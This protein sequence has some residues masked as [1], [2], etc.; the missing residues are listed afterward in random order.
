MGHKDE[1]YID[2]PHYDFDCTVLLEF[3]PARTVKKVVS[4]GNQD[5]ATMSYNYAC[6]C[7]NALRVFSSFLLTQHSPVSENLR[8]GCHPVGTFLECSVLL[9]QFSSY[10]KNNV[11]KHSQ[12]YKHGIGLNFWLKRLAT[13]G[14]LP[15]NLQMPRIKRR[16]GDLKRSDAPS[17]ATLL[18]FPLPVSVEKEFDL[19]ADQFGWGEA[20]TREAELIYKH[21]A[22]QLK[23][24]GSDVEITHDKIP[25]LVAEILFDRLEVLRNFAED[26]F[27]QARKERLRGLLMIRQGRKH[28]PFF[29]PFMAWTKGKGKEKTNPFRKRVLELSPEQ[30]DQA[31]LAWCYFKND[32]IF[33]RWGYGSSRAY[34]KWQKMKSAVGSTLGAQ[35]AQELI[36]C[37]PRMIV[38]S[39]I[40]LVHDLMA[41][42]SSVR[43]LTLTGDYASYGFLKGVSW[44]KG[45]ANKILTL[46][47]KTGSLLTPPSKVIRSIRSATKTYRKHCVPSHKSNLFLLSYQNRTSSKSSKSGD[48]KADANPISTPSST[49]FNTHTKTM[50]AEA[51]DGRWDGTAKSIRQS[52]LLYYALVDGVSG[53]QK[54]AQ[55]ADTK[56]STVYA[57]KLPMRIKLDIDIRNFL[58]WLQT[59][60]AI[61]IDDFPAK[62]RMSESDF[63]AQR[64]EILRSSFGGLYCKDPKAG[65]V[66]G[67]IKGEVC[68][69]ISQCMVCGNRRHL[70]VASEN[71]LVHLLM[72]NQALLFGLEIGRISNPP[73]PEWRMWAMFIESVL[74]RVQGKPELK[75]VLAGALDT[76]EGSDNPYLSLFSENDEEVE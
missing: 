4:I 51:S 49:W 67:T 43:G 72:W 18:D 17:S 39:Q 11:E 44:Y 73:Q 69:E 29:S 45:R 7:L 2:H 34:V 36:G 62:V 24:S 56:T 75:S 35:R 32:G 63:N 12:R 66:K 38:A 46:L 26:E 58:R 37:S 60:A 47:D 71:N 30:F 15:K 70:F 28:L 59:L 50:I 13:E 9:Q 41:N 48:K 61:D 23:D 6:Q 25:Q 52:K 27:Q 57:D 55:H 8:K 54:A 40:M 3:L 19:A 22:I 74:E 42:V 14:I 31:T 20:D 68:G 16:A 76:F 21:I 65:I 1:F 33:F 5:L 64:D 10:L 53:V